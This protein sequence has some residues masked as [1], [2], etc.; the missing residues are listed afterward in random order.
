[1]ALTLI[2]TCGAHG[3]RREIDLTSDE[4]PSDRPH[5]PPQTDRGMRTGADDG[6]GAS[7]R[8]GG[9]QDTGD[10]EVSGGGEGMKQSALNESV[11]QPDTQGEIAVRH[12]DSAAGVSTEGGLLRNAWK[13]AGVGGSHE[14]D[15][16]SEVEVMLKYASGA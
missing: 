15:A 11:T 4:I 14:P 3:H 8:E 10:N 16:G 2:W 12:S 5:T 1:M 9:A 13:A 7:T 6:T